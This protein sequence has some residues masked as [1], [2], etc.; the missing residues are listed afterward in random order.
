MSPHYALSNMADVNS[1]V[2]HEILV[3]IQ[4]R[5]YYFHFK[6][7]DVL[8]ADMPFLESCSQQAEDPG[9]KLSVLNTALHFV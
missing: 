4:G 1:A 3:A 7:A 8:R 9:F 6:E 2:S 5:N